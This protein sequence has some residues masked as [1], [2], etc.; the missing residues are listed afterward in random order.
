MIAGRRFTGAIS[1]RCVASHATPPQ[2]SPPM[3]PGTMQAAA[4]A[5][6][7]EDAVI[8]QR[9]EH[10]AARVQIRR[11]RAPEIRLRS[12][13][14]GTRLAG[15]S[16]NGC[17]GDACSP[18]TSLAGTGRSSIG[19]SGLPVS[20]SKR[21]RWPVLRTD[22][23]GRPLLRRPE[24]AAARRRRSPTGRDARSGS[25]RRTSPVA[26]R[27]RRWSWRSRCC[28]AAVRRS[29]RGW[30]AG[31]QDRRVRSRHPTTMR[32]Q[33]LAPPA[34]ASAGSGWKVQRSAPVRRIEGAH[35][36]GRHLRATVVGDV[37]PTMT[38]LRDTRRAAT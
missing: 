35:L 22:R 36:A 24:Q 15:W 4:D 32:D 3:L 29:S 37:E 16:G 20:R 14:C 26:A 31:R 17:V 9:A 38:R 18:G 8:A 28:R 30:A 21:N 11:R 12:I 19:N 2:C 34:G 27:A 25:S 10:A 7:R 1:R 5:R 33:V 23:D 6:R 13:C